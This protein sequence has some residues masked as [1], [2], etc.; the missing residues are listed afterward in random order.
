MNT[1]LQLWSVFILQELMLFGSAYWHEYITLTLL[2][3]FYWPDGCILK[4]IKPTS[5]S[6][7]QKV[8]C[9]YHLMMKEWTKVTFGLSKEP[10]NMTSFG[11]VQ[12]ASNNILYYQTG[13]VS[14]NW[15]ESMGQNFCPF[16]TPQVL[17]FT[18]GLQRG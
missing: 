17:I 13:T 6:E 1:L 11:L 10:R 14:C 12:Y 16:W 8:F 3:T 18:Q 15:N 5:W 9:L 7:S 2:F 4:N